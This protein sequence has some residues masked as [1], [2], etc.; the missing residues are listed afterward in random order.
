MIPRKE[1]ATAAVG[2]KIFSGTVETSFASL[3]HEVPS[4][5]WYHP[6][7]LS[8]S[9]PNWRCGFGLQNC[10]HQL[11][12]ATISLDWRRGENV[13]FNKLTTKT[14]TTKAISEECN[15]KKSQKTFLP[16]FLLHLHRLRCLQHMQQQIP[17]LSACCS[18]NKYYWLFSPLTPLTPSFQKERE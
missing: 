3:P 11:T 2:P 17:I 9:R 8:Y 12:K 4:P 13:L 10:L 16:F 6:T 14:T 18:F 1:L 15:I 5:L 7:A